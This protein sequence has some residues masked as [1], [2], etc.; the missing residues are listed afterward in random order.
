MHNHQ[1]EQPELIGRLFESLDGLEQ[2]KIDS[3]SIVP[4]HSLRDMHVQRLVFLGL[5]DSFEEGSTD[6]KDVTR[7]H[8]HQHK[9]KDN[10]N[11]D[12]G[13]HRSSSGSWIIVGQCHIY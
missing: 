1:E 12:E 2:E 9:D 10:S 7:P 4:F 5:Q 11:G 13:N 6:I 8:G 3:I